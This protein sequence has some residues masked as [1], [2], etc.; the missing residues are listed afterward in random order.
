MS[1]KATVE[2]TPRQVVVIDLLIEKELD[3]LNEMDRVW[4]ACDGCRN[5]E[6]GYKRSRRVEL[7]DLRESLLR[8]AG[9]SA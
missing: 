3:A 2:L 1:E 4:V 6:R 7:S 9:V 8:A 5:M